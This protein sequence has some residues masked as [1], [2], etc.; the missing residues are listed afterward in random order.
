MKIYGVYFVA[1][2]YDNW[3]EIVSEQLVTLLNS[4]L[5]TKTEKL[6]IRIYYEKKNDLE[7]F[8]SLLPNS[9]K[10]MI[11]YT[12]KNEHEYGALR[13]LKNWSKDEDFYCYYFHSKGVSITE[14][15]Y[16]KHKLEMEYIVMKNSITSWRRYMEFFLINEYEKCVQFLSLGFDACGVQLRG[17][18]RTNYLHFS[19]NFW[20]TKSDY[21]KVLPEIDSL[22]VNN[23]NL[24]EFWIGY[25][26]G[27]YKNLYFTKQAGYKEIITEDYTKIITP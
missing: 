19:G 24:A 10:I 5:F 18:P 7:L 4:K 14:K 9:D 15:T 22:D 12:D 11:S 13:V 3:F 27:N 8:K 16:H 2:I 1:L 21:I 25:G 20:W 17:T 23:R 6:H 26:N